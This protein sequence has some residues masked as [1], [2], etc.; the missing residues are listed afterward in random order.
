MRIGDHGFSGFFS[1]RGPGGGDRARIFR[2]R[3]RVGERIQGRLVRWEQPGLAWVDIQGQELLAQIHSQPAPG[4]ILAFLIVQLYP[5]IVLQELHGGA[6]GDTGAPTTLAGAVHAFWSARS[7]YESAARGL[8]PSATV[9]HHAP[10]RRLA[11]HETL[12]DAPEALARYLRLLGAAHMVNAFL[13]PM[14]AGRLC[15]PAWLLPRGALAA[16]M[17]VHGGRDGKRLDE[18]VLAFAMPRTGQCLIRIMVRPEPGAEGSCRV[19]MERPGLGRAMDAAL[20]ALL[21]ETSLACSRLET[22]P[23]APEHR[24]GLLAGLLHSGTG[25]TPGFATHV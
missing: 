13:V 16:E 18:A 24:A 3:H 9:R 21:A 7:L 4:Q 1:G 19:A 14:G 8:Q 25:G 20:D 10:K 15:Y 17:L 11:L 5:D 23:L 12:A 22:T 2:N 6:G